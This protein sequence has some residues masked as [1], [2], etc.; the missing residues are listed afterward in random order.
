LRFI[1][2]YFNYNK[3]I[4]KLFILGNHVQGLGV[5]RLAKKNGLDVWLFNHT[6]FCITRYSNTCSRF[7]KYSDQNNLLEILSHQ[8]FE[9]EKPVLIP[10]ND[11]LVWFIAENYEILS[12]KYYISLPPK[13]VVEIAYNKIKTYKIA[14][15]IGIP[16]PHS[17]FPRSLEEVIY[18][19]NDL[20]YPVVIKPAIMH[21]Y[22]TT[23]GKK[24]IKCNSSKELIVGY[25]EFTKII[26]LD[27][28]IIQEMLPGGPQNLYSF[29][30]FCDGEKV[31]A[32]L[33]ANR[34]RQKPMDFG[35]STTFAQ[36]VAVEEIENL[37]KRLLSQINYFGISEVE[38]MF[39][40]L[41]NEYKLL[42]INPRTWKWHSIANILGVDLLK[43]MLN[44]WLQIPNVENHNKIVGVGWIERLTDFFV[45]AKELSRGRMGVGQ[46]LKSLKIPKESAVFKLNDPLP[47]I[48]YIILSPILLIKR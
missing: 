23:T 2:Q 19:A 31:W 48:M 45:F 37:A 16:I 13:D 18:K 28:V 11:K 7:I 10:T 39:D 33:T 4:K 32:S 22:Y 35:I 12:E 44:I 29:G 43:P 3:L 27:E 21:T 24:M 9:N 30:S 46:Y 41:A 26:P 34:I 36:S 5:S 20:K 38:F 15:K 8:A 42:E 47:A 1:I 25:K 14:E 17:F 40:P 6:G